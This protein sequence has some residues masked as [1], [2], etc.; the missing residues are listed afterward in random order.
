MLYKNYDLPDVQPQR[1]WRAI[2]E[3]REAADP[4]ILHRELQS[5]DPQEAARHHP[6]S[7]RYIIRALEIYHV[8]GR[9]KTEHAH[10]QPVER[11]LLML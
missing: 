3:Q 9:T 11:P 8:S 6:H 1:A 7:V 10:P 2:Q 5:I 4:G